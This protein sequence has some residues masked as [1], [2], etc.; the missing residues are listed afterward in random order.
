M[1]DGDSPQVSRDEGLD[2]VGYVHDATSA[3]LVSMLMALTTPE[4]RL[5][6]VRVGTPDA[7]SALDDLL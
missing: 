3:A 6:D 4:L 1:T 2:V 5:G 7:L